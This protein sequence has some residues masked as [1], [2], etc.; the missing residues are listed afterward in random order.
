MRFGENLGG[1]LVSAAMRRVTSL[2][3]RAA[4]CGSSDGF[5]ESQPD[6]VGLEVGDDGDGDGN[7]VLYG[8]EMWSSFGCQ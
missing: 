5:W 4:W 3:L 6:R 2:A 1:S 7:G 8:A